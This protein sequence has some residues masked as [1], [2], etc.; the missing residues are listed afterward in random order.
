MNLEYSV[1]DDSPEAL[2]LSDIACNSGL[3]FTASAKNAHA[4]VSVDDVIGFRLLDE[5]DLLDFWSAGIS[6]KK[7][8]IFEITAGGWRAQE[9]LRAG[10]MSQH[11]AGIR[12]FLVVGVDW[13]LSL[14]A[15]SAPKVTWR[16]AS[17]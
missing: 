5:G 13:C 1:V 14:L 17:D 7:G 12:E 8:W 16:K 6:S 3:T 11:R 2:E 15:L 9:S 10:F 4:D